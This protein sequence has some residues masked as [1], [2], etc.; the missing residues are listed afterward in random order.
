MLNRKQRL[1]LNVI[2]V[3]GRVTRMRLVKEM[4]LIS[5]DASVYKRK[6]VNSF[7]PYKYGPFSFEMYNDLNRLMRSEH[8]KQEGE[9]IVC[10]KGLDE[11]L[12]YRVTAITKNH[13]EN[14]GA[15]ADPELIESIYHEYPE[16]TIFSKIDQKLEYDLDQT[17]IATIGYQDASI[18]SF[19][20]R[21]ITNKVQRVIDVRRNPASMK[22]MFSKKRMSDILSKF[23]IDYSHIPELG[24]SSE[25][26]K[27]LNSYEDYQRL[28][29]RYRERIKPDNP[30]LNDIIEYGQTQMIA[31]MCYEKD[32][33]YCHRGLL[34]DMSRSRGFGVIEI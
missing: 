18:D 15:L 1:L 14:L 21:L 24:I 3:H 16:Y 7:V 10:E 17:G 13:L 25:E 33:D 11:H 30:W 27:D 29:H 34:T 26:R 5:K 8:I 22:A 12:D 4:F 6:P 2:E 23:Q 32:P 20:S 9:E 19:L 28:F 31:L